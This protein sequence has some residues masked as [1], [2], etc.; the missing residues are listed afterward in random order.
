MMDGTFRRGTSTK[1]VQI[2]KMGEN[3]ARLNVVCNDLLVLFEENKVPEIQLARLKKYIDE[4]QQADFMDVATGFSHSMAF[5]DHDLVLEKLYAGWR[6]VEE[7][8]KGEINHLTKR[9]NAMREDKKHDPDKLAKLESDKVDAEK[10]KAKVSIL[11]GIMSLQREIPIERFV[12]DKTF[13]G[14]EYYME[15]KAEEQVIT[16]TEVAD[17]GEVKESEK[18]EGDDTLNSK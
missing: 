9:V 2:V 16:E 1:G 3:L 18:K 12:Q 8:T 7:I 10:R 11:T 4:K 5:L 13:D 14:Y 17:I 15:K 6:F